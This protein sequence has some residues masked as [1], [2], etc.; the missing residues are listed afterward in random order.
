[1]ILVDIYIPSMG[2]TY[3]FYLDEYATIENQLDEIHEML[4][5]N[6]GEHENKEMVDKLML[7]SYEYQMVLPRDTTLSQAKIKTG[8]KLFLV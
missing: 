7:C 4:L 3:D 8:S 5:Q 6:T 1:M 2:E